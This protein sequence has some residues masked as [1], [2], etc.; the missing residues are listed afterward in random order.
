ME[1]R[2]TSR[3]RTRLPITISI[4]RQLK[5]VWMTANPAA[6]HIMLW[7][8]ACTGF[9]GFLRAGEF[10]VPSP[11]EYDSDVHLNLSD[12]AIDDHRLPSMIRLCIK[13]SKTDPFRQGIHV[14][15]GKT[16]AAVCPVQAIIR[17]IGVRRS[18]PGPLFIR[19]SGVP[20]TRTFL[21]SELK[22]ALRSL[23]VD[24]SLY[25]GHSFRIGAATTA[26][27]QGLQDSLIQTLG[28]W[29]SEAY[30]IYIKLP[31]E[32]LAAVSR[33]LARGY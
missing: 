9:F 17:Y 24:E 25:N 12:M 4:M 2:S 1:S 27:Q 21:V 15:L 5:T 18:D 11:S 6:D 3:S 8:A 31:R 30:K 14:F 23:K 7:A 16:E 22:V 20:L 10:T 33:T 29:R 28:R 19:S 26:A 13:Q 32:Q